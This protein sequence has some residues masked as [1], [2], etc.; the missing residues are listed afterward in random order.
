M[1]LFMV[2]KPLIVDPT[3]YSPQST[4]KQ[5]TALSIAIVLLYTNIKYVLNFYQSFNKTSLSNHV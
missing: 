4:E 1:S 5:K 3:I 2:P